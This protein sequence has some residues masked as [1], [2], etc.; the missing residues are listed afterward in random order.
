MTS[1]RA[2]P[3]LPV[4][5]TVRHAFATIPANWQSVLRI[6]WAWTAVMGILWALWFL[7]FP[8]RAFP[9]I[10]TPPHPSLSRRP[11]SDLS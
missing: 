1:A 6:F 10:G 9:P 11:H 4:W 3:T 2:R 8:V 7:T 5:P